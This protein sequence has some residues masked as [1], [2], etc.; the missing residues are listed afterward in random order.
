MTNDW[1]GANAG[2]GGASLGPDIVPGH[3]APNTLIPIRPL[4]PF[5]QQDQGSLFR[6][7]GRRG[8]LPP[9]Y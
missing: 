1:R 7:V 8:F 2:N 4:A 5:G 9:R 6:R 3:D